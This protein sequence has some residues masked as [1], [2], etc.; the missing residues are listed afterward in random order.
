VKA[1]LDP[2]SIDRLAQVNVSTGW[3]VVPDHLCLLAGLPTG[4]SLERVGAMVGAPTPADR[5]ELGRRALDRDRSE[6][7]MRV[8]ATYQSLTVHDVDD[9]A[10]PAL[11]WRAAVEDITAM[12]ESLLAT[13]SAEVGPYRSVLV[14][15]GWLHNPLVRA[16]KE[17][18]YGG[19]GERDLHEPGAVGAAEMAGI[20][21]GLVSPRWQ[22]AVAG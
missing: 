2:A 12:S 22:P 21:A 1:P 17:S 20:A 13:M 5:I 15:G 10:D 19:F 3:G 11:V 6:T 14:A 18:Q 9:E 4:I 8:S 16:V 7:A